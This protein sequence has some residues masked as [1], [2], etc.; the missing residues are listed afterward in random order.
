MTAEPGPARAVHWLLFPAPASA[1]ALEALAVSRELGVTWVDERT[2]GWQPGVLLHGPFPPAELER[3]EGLP[4]WV[5]EMWAVHV[6]R[7]RGPAIPIELQI[8]GSALA[9]F[10]DGEPMG[11]ER[12]TLET[13]EAL[14]RRLGGAVLTETGEIVVPDLRIDLLLFSSSWIDAGDLTQALRGALG[15]AVELQTEAGPAV[16]PEVEPEGYGLVGEVSGGGVLSV[17]ASPAEATPI[18]LAGYG[19]ANG[20]VY[21]YEFRYYPVEQFSFSAQV[22][23][24]RTPA[25]AEAFVDSAAASLVERAAAA[26]LEATGGPRSGHLCDDDSFLVELP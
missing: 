12:E 5:A 1:A 15:A 8:P 18:A 16:P 3:S 23:L 22:N 26:A 9:A 7:E 17:S 20:S 21:V 19:W 11:M 13:L 6:P 10:P 25:E 24:P 14:A 2:L 4:G